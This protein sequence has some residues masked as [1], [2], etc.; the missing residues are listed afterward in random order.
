MAIDDGPA[1][2][3]LLSRYCDAVAAHDEA[4]FR[5]CWTAD[6]R[7]TGPGLDVAGRDEIVRVWAKMRAR[8]VTAVQTIEAGSV[9]LHGTTATGAWHIR[10]QMVAVDGS[11]RE[12]V[13]TYADE[14]E[15]GDEGWRFARRAFTPR[16]AVT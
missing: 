12:T 4:G 8:Y 15:Y 1:I 5:S 2:T 11:T 9:D 6:A 16:P 7:W 14:Y 10:E 3:E 13:G